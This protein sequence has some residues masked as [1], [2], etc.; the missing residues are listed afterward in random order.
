MVVLLLTTGCVVEGYENHTPSTGDL[1]R[2]ADEWPDDD[3]VK[4]TVQAIA[5]ERYATASALEAQADEAAAALAVAEATQQAARQAAERE[6]IVLTAQAHERE[7]AHQRE[8][9][10]QWQQ[11]TA[12]A[13]V[14][15]QSA[16]ATQQAIAI[17]ATRQAQAIEATATER[18]YQA[19]S[20]AEAL[21]QE[22]TATAHYRADIATSTRQ[23]WEGR[24]TATA[25]AHTATAQVAHATMTRQAERREETLGY[26]RDY[27]IPVVLL[28]IVGGISAL[29]IYGLRQYSKRPVVYQRNLLGDAEPMAVPVEGGGYTFVDLD[30]QP[31]P[32]LQV[33]FDGAINAPLL[34]SAG[35]EE[36]TTGRDQMVDAMTRP[37]LGG[38]HQG[39]QAP[40][41]PAPPQAPA[42]GLRSV[43]MLHRLDQ[44][45]SAGFLPPPLVAS[46][47]EDWEFED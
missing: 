18:A 33:L 4:P 37:K 25:E 34:R 41:L 19:T 16:M 6:Y 11:A 5:L 20:T 26:A 47:A 30:R 38:G 29:V 36:R 9:E 28:I 40:V 46:L 22:A 3:P 1:T 39:T 44:A 27:G 17:E 14:A 23:A 15:T 13:A 35:Q 45:E 32:A 24:V 43:R 12:Q 7:L 21:N 31:G 10:R 2:I 8:L 42:P